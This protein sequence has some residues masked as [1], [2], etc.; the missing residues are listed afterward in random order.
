M[1]VRD[2]AGWLEGLGHEVR[3]PA[4][5]AE[6]V[7]LEKWAIDDDLL[8]AD[9]DLAVSVG[10]DGTMLRTVHLVCDADVPVLGVNVG[11]LGYLT[12][13]E[14]AGMT[15]GIE[16]W[17]H[18]RFH[19]ERRMTLQVEV[20]RGDRSTGT[21]IA[22]NDAVL[23]RTGAGHTVRVG[24]TIDGAHWVTYV[25]DGLIVAT[26]TGS[27]AYNLSAR[28]P[29][30]SPDHRAIVLTPVAPHMLLNVPLVLSGTEEVR[31]D[32]VE[33]RPADLVVDGQTIAS[34]HNGDGVICRAG[35]HDARL[36]TF[37]R[38]DFHRIVKAKFGLEG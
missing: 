36:V 21:H 28:G 1:L 6:A 25:A 7:G 29:I 30:V 38:R 34:L 27:T 17:L 8:T 4:E 12:E 23:Q 3:I 10:G 32:L 37:H 24:T 31:F 20:V 26:P 15:D 22:L 13:V 33:S 19:I 35:P 14:P 2:T 16:H 18:G 9:L 11:H 5:D